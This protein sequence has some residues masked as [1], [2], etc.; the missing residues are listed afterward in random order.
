MRSK[1][2]EAY[3]TN[4]QHPQPYLEPALNSNREIIMDIFEAV[5]KG[6]KNA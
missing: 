3:Y 1:G 4:G 6:S 2:L 5:L